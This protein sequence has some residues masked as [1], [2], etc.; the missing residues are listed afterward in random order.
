[1]PA[2]DEGQQIEKRSCQALV[3]FR[4]KPG[5]PEYQGGSRSRAAVYKAEIRENPD[6]KTRPKG[7]NRFGYR[8]L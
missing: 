7:K 6:I 4:K 1:M 8:G 5:T 3:E 2:G